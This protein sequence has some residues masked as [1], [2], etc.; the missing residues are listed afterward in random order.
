MMFSLVICNFPEIANIEIKYDTDRDS[1]NI[2]RRGVKM[3]DTSII[4]GMYMLSSN[5]ILINAYKYTIF[6]IY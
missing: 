6:L 5:N 4:D 3:D 2:D 1:K